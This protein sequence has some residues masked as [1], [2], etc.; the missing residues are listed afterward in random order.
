MTEVRKCAGCGAVLTPCKEFHLWID[1]DSTIY[2]VDSKKCLRCAN[3]DSTYYEDEQGKI[4]KV[5][6]VWADD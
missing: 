4:R 6:W 1:E 5:R 3:C 2:D